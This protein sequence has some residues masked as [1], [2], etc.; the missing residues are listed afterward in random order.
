MRNNSPQLIQLNQCQII[1][2]F[3]KETKYKAIVASVTTITT[4]IVDVII[5][6]DY[7]RQFCF[8]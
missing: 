8:D 7:N 5:D 6:V 4:S 2:C 3:Q 1:Y